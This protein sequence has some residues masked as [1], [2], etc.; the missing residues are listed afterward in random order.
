MS[1]L[2]WQRGGAATGPAL[3][4]CHAVGGDGPGT[5]GALAEAAG[6]A[7]V[8][9]YVLDLPGHGESAAV[10]PPSDVNPAAWTAAAAIDDLTRMGVR[11]AVAVGIGDGCLT[12]AALAAARE[13]PISGL[14]LAG[15]DDSEGVEGGHA[16]ADHLRGEGRVWSAEVADRAAALVRDRRH[17]P[18][19]IA[20]WAD[21]AVWP[22][23][24]R[25]GALRIPV[26]LAVAAADDRRRSRISRLAALF[27]DGHVV[28]IAGTADDLASTADL[29]RHVTGLATATSK[30]GP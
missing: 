7:G 15:T 5:W 19:V 27:H 25:L 8:G 3:V 14:V 13:S 12:A 29:H 9:V 26:M 17:D 10:V 22:A 24:P 18:A 6:A 30:T 4:C 16:V 2:A 20:A 1:L 23:A 28:T 21:R 11:R